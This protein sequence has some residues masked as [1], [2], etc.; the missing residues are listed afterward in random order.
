MCV[1]VFWQGS[2]DEDGERENKCKGGMVE[3][4]VTWGLHF[5]LHLTTMAL[6]GLLSKEETYIKQCF[7]C[8]L[9]SNFYFRILD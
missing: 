3:Y 9:F 7:A 6:E 5:S 8:S 1:C 2:R 4:F